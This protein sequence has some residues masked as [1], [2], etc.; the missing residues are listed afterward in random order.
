MNHF[1]VS[2]P[3]F[4]VEGSNSSERERRREQGLVQWKKSG[5]VWRRVRGLNIFFQKKLFWPQERERVGQGAYKKDKKERDRQKERERSVRRKERERDSKG[6]ENQKTEMCFGI[7]AP[8]S[9]CESWK[10]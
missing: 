6:G 10:P 7:A 2:R 5:F 1:P 8:G 3:T 9:F 4:C